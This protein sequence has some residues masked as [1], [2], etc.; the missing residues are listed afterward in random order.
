ML[1]RSRDVEQWMRHRRLP[2]DLK[3]YEIKCS[4]SSNECTYTLSTR[5]SVDFCK[6][7]V[8]NKCLCYKRLIKF[9]YPSINV[10]QVINMNFV[11]ESTAG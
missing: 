1:L 2:E 7:M 3:K 10:V 11:Q 8:I 4:N 9:F 6:S 5:V